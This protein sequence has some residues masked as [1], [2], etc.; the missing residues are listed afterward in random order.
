MRSESRPACEV[1]PSDTARCGVAD[2]ATAA[3][4]DAAVRNRA[5][6]GLRVLAIAV[7]VCGHWLNAVV[8]VRNG[9]LRMGYVLLL[10]PGTQHLTWLLQVM[11]LFFLVGGFANAA[12]WRSAQR[13]GEPFADWFRGRA[14]RLLVPAAV[15]VGVW[16]VLGIV[17]VAVGLELPLVLTAARHALGPLWFL[18]IYLVVVAAVPVTLRLHDRHGWRA[19]AGLA[20]LAVATDLGRFAAGVPAV[21]WAN[22]GWVWVGLHQLGY[23]WQDGRLLRSPRHAA[24]LLVGGG[25]AFGLLVDLGPYPVNLVDRVHTAPASL[26]LFALGCAQAGLVLLLRGAAGRWLAR[27]RVWRAV[28]AANGVAMTAYLWHVT[29]MMLVALALVVPGRWPD[30]PV[31]STGWWA[32]RPAWLLVSAAATFPVVGLLAGVERRAARHAR[33]RGEVEQ[34]QHPVGDRP[35]EGDHA[36]R[37]EDVLGGDH[38][39]DDA[40]QVAVGARDDAAQHVPGPRGRVHLQDLRDPREVLDDRVAPALPDLQGAERRDRVAQ[41]LGLDLRPVPGHDAA[42]AQAPQAGLDGAAGDPQPA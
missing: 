10:V 1:H 14:G 37:L 12:G 38:E 32:L 34:G 11:P 28:Q 18:G 23:G 24:G 41:R 13:R 29:A 30:L 40:L 4:G 33:L 35:G 36:G 2:V 8:T 26:A 22:C 6:D 19:A 16:T 5:V 39:V 20:V 7:V 9:D 42:V 25:A 21:G 15:L 3:P 17:L 31:S 27:P